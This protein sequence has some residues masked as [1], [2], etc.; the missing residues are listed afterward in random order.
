M[1][2]VSS[3]SAEVLSDTEMSVGNDTKCQRSQPWSAA[4]GRTGAGTRRQP[5][6]GHGGH[7]RIRQ[8]RAR[9]CYSSGLQPSLLSPGRLTPWSG[10]GVG[11]VVAPDLAAGFGHD[12]RIVTE[13]V[14][15]G[16]AQPAQHF[17]EADGRV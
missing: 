15:E 7:R 6:E 13:V 4:A 1:I 14:R 16:Q 5:V 11:P 9:S 3:A 2:M 10:V 12:G 8:V 17:I